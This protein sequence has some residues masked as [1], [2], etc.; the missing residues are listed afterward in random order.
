MVAQFNKTNSEGHA[1][2]RLIMIA[3][4]AFLAASVAPGHAFIDYFFGGSQTRDSIDNSAVGDLRAWWTGNP[5][6]QFNPYYSGNA[7]PGQ[8]ASGMSNPQDMQQSAPP[9]GMQQQGYQP[10]P[11]PQPSVT[12]FPQQGQQQYGYE[13]PQGQYQGQPIYGAA[14]ASLPIQGPPQTYQQ[15]VQQYQQSP[16][17]QYQQPA[18]YQPPVQYQQPAQYQQPTQYQQPAQAYQQPAGYPNQ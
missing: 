17:Q 5:A 15:P 18:Q 13:P 11:Q 6:Y 9:M 7:N 1:M 8:S 2:K 12:Y 4:L 3:V 14:G 10:Q 16:Q